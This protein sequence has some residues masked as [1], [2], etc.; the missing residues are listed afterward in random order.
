MILNY[1][2]ILSDYSEMSRVHLSIRFD[3]KFYSKSIAPLLMFYQLL[4][5]AMAGKIWALCVLSK[6]DWLS[7]LMS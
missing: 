7:K 6:F 2:E 5:V 3:I 1:S 4:Q